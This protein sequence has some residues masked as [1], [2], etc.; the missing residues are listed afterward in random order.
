MRKG[1]LEINNH[2]I[3]Q[4]SKRENTA[5]AHIAYNT[6]IY[7]YDNNNSHDIN[8]IYSIF[9]FNQN[10]QHSN[11]CLPTLISTQTLHTPNRIQTLHIHIYISIVDIKLINMPHLN[12]NRLQQPAVV[13]VFTQFCI[14][15]L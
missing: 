13:C 12:Y 7:I 4:S 6:H 9:G 5:L 11:K 1:S 10:L 14:L 2:T 15:Y 8:N 3:P